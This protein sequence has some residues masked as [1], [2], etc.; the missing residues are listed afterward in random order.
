MFPKYGVII[1]QTRHV[2]RLK[3]PR[4]KVRQMLGADLA[5]RADSRSDTQHNVIAN[6]SQPR[7]KKKHT[8]WEKPLN[9][10]RAEMLFYHM[11]LSCTLGVC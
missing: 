7:G 3:M 6:V 2:T 5:V 8:V 9:Y 1:C 4:R 11:L 10:Q